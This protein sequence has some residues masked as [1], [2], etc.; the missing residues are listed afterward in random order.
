MLVKDK[1]KKI[2]QYFIMTFF[3]ILKNLHF[4]IKHLEKNG[5]VYYNWQ[6]YRYQVFILTKRVTVQWYV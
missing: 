3:S 2:H 1:H 4:L 5:H 6:Q